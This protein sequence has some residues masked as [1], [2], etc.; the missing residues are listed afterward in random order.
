MV[1]LVCEA[2][3]FVRCKIYL[4]LMSNK[5]KQASNN[6]LCVRFCGLAVFL[7]LIETGRCCPNIRAKN[8]LQFGESANV[9]VESRIC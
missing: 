8:D 2:K 9:T 5:T 3:L 4:L 7:G 6:F 1:G